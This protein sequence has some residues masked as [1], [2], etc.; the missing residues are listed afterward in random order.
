MQS[1]TA[2]RAAMMMLKSKPEQVEVETHEMLLI[3]M[4]CGVEPVDIPLC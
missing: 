2:G 1:S 4:F 3:V